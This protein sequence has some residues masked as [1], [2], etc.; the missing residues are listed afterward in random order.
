[1]QR[2]RRDRAIAGAGYRC[3]GQDRGVG[4]QPVQRLVLERSGGRGGWWGWGD[5][6]EGL[7]LCGA[8]GEPW[9]AT[10]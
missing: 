6:G 8:R 7:V 1:M 10:T 4:V 3:P 9:G 5:L 2:R